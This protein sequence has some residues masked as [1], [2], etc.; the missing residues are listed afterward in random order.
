MLNTHSYYSFK[1]GLRSIEELIDF[2]KNGGYKSLA[3]TDINTTAGTL[4]FM[5]QCQKQH[6]KPLVGIDFRN[7]AEQQFIGIARNNEGFRKLNEYLSFY[8][9]NDLRI[10]PQIEIEDCFIIYPFDKRPERDLKLYEY[11]GLRPDEVNKLR[12][13]K[14]SVDRSRLITCP[15]FTF[16]PVAIDEEFEMHQVLR[17]I[18]LNTLVSK[19]TDTDSGSKSD[20]FLTKKELLTAY[21]VLPQC[22]E[23][24][25]YVVANCAVH[26][27]F[28]ENAQP[29]NL[30]TWTGSLEGDYQKIHELCLT[31]LAY[32]YGQNPPFAIKRRVIKEMQIIRQQGFLSYFLISWDL[33]TYAR[34]KG[35]F[36]V[37]R[38]SGAN[39]IVAYLLRITDV[40]PVDLDLYFER[41]INLFR[42]NPPDFDIDFSWMDRED[43]TRY[44]FERYDHVALI[45]TYI[46]FQFKSVIREVGKAFGV[47]DHEIERIQ[48][49]PDRDLD[50]HHKVIL[51]YGH[52]IHGFPSHLSVHA[53]GVLIADKPIHSFTAT[54]LP[55]KGFPI[56]HFDM[57]IAEDVGL[58]KY[59][60]LAQRG[61][62][63][64]KDALSLIEQ[65][66]PNKLAFDIH[67][68]KR[69]K[70]DELVKQNLRIANAIGCFYIESPAMRQLM[71]K[72]QVDNYLGLVAAS[73]VIRP[74]VAQSG[75]MRQYIQR[76]RNPEKRKEA[77]PVLLKIMPETYG[78]MVYQEDVIKV[79]HYFAGLD[80]GEADVLRRGMSGK[81]RSREEF[82]AVKDKFFNNCKAK[83][84][85]YELTAD[86][87]RQIESFAGY[88]FAKGHSASYAVES[89]Q[90]LF[91]KSYFPLEFMVAVLNNGGGFYS[92]EFYV[93][94]ARMQG[95]RIIAPHLNKSDYLAK[96]EGDTIYLGFNQVKDLEEGIIHALLR[97]RQKGHFDSVENLVKRVPISLDQLSLLIRVGAFSFLKENKKALLWKAHF[98]LGNTGKSKVEN[99]LFEPTVKDYTLPDITHT[100]LE[101]MYDEM[102]LL[103]FPLSS[104]FALLE[105]IPTGITQGSEMKNYINKRVEMIGYLVHIKNTSTL[106]KERMQFGTFVDQAGAFIDSVHFPPVAKKYPFTGRGIYHLYGRV[107]EDFGALSLE[108][109][110][111]VK[112]GYRGLE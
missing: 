66:R 108:V 29:Q 93:H 56:T 34:S 104:P 77:H 101:D 60:I 99:L 25:T 73:S 8:L 39:S 22:I 70:E 107:V 30:K 94:E 87:W 89:Y 95:A 17:A 31:G 91:L 44:L 69:F 18:D 64:I 40:D 46:T 13:T 96:I 14:K 6:I 52:R 19:L 1:Y 109:D 106:R 81:Y 11:I 54:S 68:I 41:F 28:N 98:L 51:K 102:A 23:N 20:I 55:P 74:G 90:S 72:L 35:Y 76:Y 80:L 65:N 32:R 75:M 37:G 111:M 78:V 67:D 16:Y 12:F 62:G 79:A 2:A 50:H 97:E 100:R 84:Y 82:Q 42:K 9:H 15:T 4:E 36:Y 58:Y 88:A 86:V 10:P 71:I 85:T 83:G 7:G 92:T 103:G 21:E 24:L 38:G 47:P 43:V 27:D 61:L 45:A 63:K 3:I 112:L 59:D 49:T 57:V 110:R 105:T 5:R 26:F 53:G 33:V 48:K